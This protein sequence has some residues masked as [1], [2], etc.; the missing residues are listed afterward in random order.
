[1]KTYRKFIG[2]YTIVRREWVRMFR[3]WVGA[4]LPPIVTSILYFIIFGHVL[5]QRMGNLNGATYIQFITPGLIMMSVITNAYSA[6]VSGFFS[7]KFSRDIEEILI[8]PMPA[9]ILVSGFMVA[10]MLR[11]VLVGS[12]VT[13]I[14]LI[15]V[16]LSVHS[17]PVVI[18][19]TL[20][21]SAI[22]ALGGILNAMYAK[23]FDD[24]SLIPTFVLTP[25]TYLGG[26][27]YSIT[28]LPLFWQKLSLLNPIVY[29]INT[30]RYG[31]LGLSSFSLFL[32]MSVMGIVTL[33]L[34][35][36]TWYL[37]SRGAGLK[38]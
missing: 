10:G 23:S 27:F 2:F 5:G 30:F 38:N 9:W 13:L 36:T 37:V 29:I 35:F 20:L 6:T 33:F 11:G 19:V 25:M 24:I 17:L 32:E 28:W 16:P 26:V 21:A 1:M 31:L 3:V 18:L 12:L 14:A 34:F 8:T 4:L 22:F 15:F 7:M